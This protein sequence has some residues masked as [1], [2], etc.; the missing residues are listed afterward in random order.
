MVGTVVFVHGTGV[1]KAGYAAT[2]GAVQEGLQARLPDVGVV[3]VPWGEKYGVSPQDLGTALPLQVLTRDAAGVSPLTDADRTAARW[4]LLTD[5]PLF[6]LRL[7]GQLAPASPGFTF[8]TLPEQAVVERLRLVRQAPPD[9]TGSGISTAE[10]AEAIGWV[11]AA[12]ELTA[13]ARGTTGPDDPDLAEAIASAAVARLLADHRLDEPG[14][15]PVI[16]L[17]GAI[18]DTLVRQLQEAITQGQARA[19]PGWLKGTM[20]KFAE[21]RATTVVTQRRTAL[22]GSSFP[23]IGDILFYQRRGEDIRRLV[24]SALHAAA[25][26]VVAVGHSLG[27]IILADLLSGPQPPAVSTLVTVGS[28]APLFYLMDALVYLRCGATQPP[29]FTPWLNIYNPQDF[30][31]FCAERVFPAVAGICDQEVEP[32]V[33]FPASHSAYWHH[34]PVYDLIAGTWP[35]P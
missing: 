9:V 21:R 26:P 20:V 33:P 3:G 6:E 25:P 22:M 16:T 7:V 23:G 12:S 32:G 28:Q 8:G 10:F 13:A 18:R 34:G 15:A 27:G 14:T 11:A 31:S 17:D 29:P 19:V 30:L 35:Q 5:D 4:A 2:L 24:A 1:R